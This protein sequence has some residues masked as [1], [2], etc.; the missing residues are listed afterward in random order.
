MLPASESS[1][2]ASYH[3]N[4]HKTEKKS[5]FALKNSY[6]TVWGSYSSLV[7]CCWSPFHCFF[8]YC[9]P[10]VVLDVVSARGCVWSWAELQ[11]LRGVVALHQSWPACG[12]SLMIKSSMNANMEP[13]PVCSYLVIAFDLIRIA[14]L[15]T[16]Y[17]KYYNT[18]AWLKS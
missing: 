13:F 7:W 10:V 14:I 2:D 16:H 4:A 18:A 1:L 12:H 5:N 17:S 15:R 6:K 11:K 9:F 8:Y 3:S